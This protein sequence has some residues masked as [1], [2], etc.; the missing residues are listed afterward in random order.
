MLSSLINSLQ[1][2]LPSFAL[3]SRSPRCG[4]VANRAVMHKIFYDSDGPCVDC[5]NVLGSSELLHCV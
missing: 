4:D 5:I 2:L 1:Q 3:R